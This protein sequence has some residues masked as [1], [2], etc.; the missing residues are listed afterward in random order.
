MGKMGTK[1]EMSFLAQW[2]RPPCSEKE[3]D[4]FISSLAA[5]C[6][7]FGNLTN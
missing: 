2:S 6:M 5:L 1:E 4:N 3:K 7:V